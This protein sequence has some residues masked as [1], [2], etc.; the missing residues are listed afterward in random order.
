M[1]SADS[2]AKPLAGTAEYGLTEVQKLEKESKEMEIR[3]MLL[4]ERI[5][6]EQREIPCGG[7]WQSAQKERGSLSGYSKEVLTK[8]R[9]RFYSK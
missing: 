4:K 2:V 9:K 5:L 8:Y 3:L 6:K 1:K 7:K